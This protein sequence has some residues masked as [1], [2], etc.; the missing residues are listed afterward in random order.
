MKIL[1]HG[2]IDK[3]ECPECEC[4]FLMNKSEAIQQL[5]LNN[6]Y[7]CPECGSTQVQKVKECVRKKCSPPNGEI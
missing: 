2:T 4:V 3:F 1:K 7:Q 5:T 6:N